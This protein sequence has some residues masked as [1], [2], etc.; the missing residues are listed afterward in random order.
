MQAKE[1]LWIIIPSVLLSLGLLWYFRGIVGYVLVA[2]VLSLIGQPLIGMLDK[3]QFRKFRLPNALKALL[4]LVLMYGILGILFLQLIPPIVEQGAQLQN[5]DVSRI[6]S[7]VHDPL[8]DAEVALRG[9]RIYTDSL[10]L[11]EYL[12]QRALTFAS[13][14]NVSGIVNSIAGYTGDFFV[15]FFTV[16]FIAFF[17]LKDRSLFARIALT[18]TPSKYITQVKTILS[19]TRRLLSRYF[20]GMLIELLLVWGLVS[21]GLWIFG[22]PNSLLIG[23]FAGLLNVIPYVGPLLGAALGGTLTLISGLQLELYSETL[24]MVAKAVAVCI[25]V[26]WIDNFVVMPYISSNS[27][28]AHPLEI[29]L[30]TIAAAQIGGIGG[31]ILAVPTYTVLR[32]IAREFFSHFKVV[33]SITREM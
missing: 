13:A 3:V 10:S 16:S 23:F 17:F 9:Y 14:I 19:E 8:H 18:L 28:K 6:E 25:V 31:M 12:S 22:V 32:L 29:F 20:I 2:A 7:S 5:F 30:V 33:Q 26:Q 4:T 21:L 27:V 1:R 11:E 15:A 24:P